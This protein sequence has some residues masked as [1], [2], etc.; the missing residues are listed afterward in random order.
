MFKARLVE[1][2]ILRHMFE[3]VEHLRE[4][5]MD[6]MVSRRMSLAEVDLPA[7]ALDY[8]RCDRPF[9]MA[10]C[11]QA[12]I[13][14]LK[15]VKD[16]DVVTLKAWVGEGGQ[17]ETLTLIRKAPGDN[18][19]SVFQLRWM[20]VLDF[21]KKKT[22]IH[23]TKYKCSARMPVQ[24]CQG[25]VRKVEI[26]QR[27]TCFITCSEKGIQFT[28]LVRP[29][30]VRKAKFSLGHVVSGDECN[31]CYEAIDVWDR[32]NHMLV[33][34]KHTFHRKCLAQW[35]DVKMECPICRTKLPALSL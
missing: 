27:K 4:G 30:V 17:S 19:T 13:T 16:N 18:A 6:R 35:M 15:L 7:A 3:S 28:C 9:S 12:L 10:L 31:I 33:P 8:Y 22:R 25:F 24:E 20:T 23:D 1:G 26:D 34:C 5:A 11:C 32:Q 2:V 14:I 29:Q 21:E